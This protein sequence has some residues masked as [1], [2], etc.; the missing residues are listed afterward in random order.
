MFA[1]DELLVW[2]KKTRLAADT[3]STKLIASAILEL[4]RSCNDWKS[5]ND[6]ISLL[7][8]RR[9]QLKQVVQEVIR[10]GVSY[11]DQAP[12]TSSKYELIETLRDV[13]S[14]KVH[15]IFLKICTDFFSQIFVE[16]ER[17]RL[18]KTL[19]EMKE[20][21]GK[22]SEA[23]DIL[24]EV[25]VETVGSMEKKEKAEF[26]LEQIRLT[27]DK[28]DYIRSSLIAQKVSRKVLEEQDFQQLKIKF[29][30]LM[31]RYHMHESNYLEICKAYHAIYRTP[32]V[33]EDAEQSKRVTFFTLMFV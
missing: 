23:A 30:E 8:K 1:L 31:I 24:Q 9:A 21:E 33:Q 14:G 19:A 18:T 27:L 11:V 10:K 7:C 22:I 17:A 13:S 16:L 28:H 12:D 26:L 15:L 2:E 25:Q 32:C 20:K 29:Y 5:L 3:S 4:I 6:H